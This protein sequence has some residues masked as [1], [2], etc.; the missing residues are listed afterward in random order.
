MICMVWYAELDRIKEHFQHLLSETTFHVWAEFSKLAA[1][2]KYHVIRLLWWVVSHNIKD[3][4]FGNIPRG[5]G[6]TPRRI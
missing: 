4:A 3:E 1:H 6:V 5:F 2:P